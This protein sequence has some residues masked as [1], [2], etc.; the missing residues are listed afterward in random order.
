MGVLI[1]SKRRGLLSKNI[2]RKSAGRA[3]PAKEKYC[4]YVN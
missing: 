3:L 2:E 1:L 4:K